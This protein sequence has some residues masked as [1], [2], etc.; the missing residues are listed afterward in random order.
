MRHSAAAPSTGTPHIR[1]Y[2]PA[3]REAFAA[4][5]VATA[6]EGGDSAARYPDRELMP[7]VF[8]H[9]YAELEPDFAFV[10][11]D[12]TGTAGGYVVGAPDTARFAERFRAEWLPSA[13]ARFPLP[14]GEPRTPSDEI[15]LLLHRPERMVRPELAGHPAHLHI[16]LLP[17]WQG[18]GWGRALMRTLLDALHAAGV[19]AVHLS[20][21]QANTGAR[22]FY[23][24]LGFRP[25]AVPET[26]PLWYLGRPTARDAFL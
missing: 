7:S 20:M 9:P 8:A 17:A 14:V 19:P 3:D 11:D 13:G 10:L 2:R 24:R 1:R 5:C 26:A 6:H 23:D 15:V 12:G 25:L 16:D 22:A 4:V 18:R 21:V